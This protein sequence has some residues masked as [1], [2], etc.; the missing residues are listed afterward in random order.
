LFDVVG[1]VGNDSINIHINIGQPQ[2]MRQVFSA[3]QRMQMSLVAK[4]AASSVVILTTG[5]EEPDST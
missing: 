2:R 1:C 5:L 4:I 3:W